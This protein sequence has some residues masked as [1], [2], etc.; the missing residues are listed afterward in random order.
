MSAP[1]P[2]SIVEID[3]IKALMD[4]DQ[5]VI[6]CGGG[7]IPVLQQDNHLKGA[8]AV[9]EKDLAAGRMAEE[10]DADELIILTSVEKVKINIGRPEEE[11]LGEIT[12]EQAKRYMDE[13]HFGKYNMLPK[14]SASVAFIEKREGRG[15]LITSFDKLDAALKG[16]TGTVIK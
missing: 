4:A 15:A 12:V 2:V 9:I 1:N 16:K 5:I 6:A 8:S 10:I 7:G 13:G 3:A 11:E 14:F